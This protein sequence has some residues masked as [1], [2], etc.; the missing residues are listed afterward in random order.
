M[1]TKKYHKGI[2]EVF[3][4]KKS[5]ATANQVHLSLLIGSMASLMVPIS[6]DYHKPFVWVSHAMHSLWD[7]TTRSGAMDAGIKF[8]LVLVC[9]ERMIMMIYE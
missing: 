8:M 3:R 1:T 6:L 5:Q 7:G 4:G 2:D 9:A